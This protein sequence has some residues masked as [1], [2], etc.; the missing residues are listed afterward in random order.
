VTLAAVLLAGLGAT[1]AVAGEKRPVAGELQFWQRTCNAA[2][3]C[4][5]PVAASERLEVAGEVE[6]PASPGQ[7]GSWAQ[8]FTAEGGLALKLTV[9]WRIGATPADKGWFAT[10]ADLVREGEGGAVRPLAQCSQYLDE[11]SAQAFPVGACAGFVEVADGEGYVEYGVT[12][13]KAK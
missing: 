11:T 3:E 13:Y 12:F 2:A 10:Q 8:R 6:R 1:P 9:F 5:L 7:L 4:E